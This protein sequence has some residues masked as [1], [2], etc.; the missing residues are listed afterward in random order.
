MHM[1]LHKQN[2][3]NTIA[4]PSCQTACNQT[5]DKEVT[6]LKQNEQGP[7]VSYMNS[8]SYR[9]GYPHRSRF[10]GKGNED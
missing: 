5:P 1:V 3:I 2:K 7:G 4:F 10:H 9:T 8:H 6:N